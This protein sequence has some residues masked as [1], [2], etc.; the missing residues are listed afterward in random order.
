MH[1]QTFIITLSLEGKIT[2]DNQIKEMARNIADA[3]LKESK[4]YGLAPDSSD[5]YV[6]VIEVTPEF[7]PNDSIRLTVL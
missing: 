6:K 1:A 5:A 7:L 2:D 4:E 3:L